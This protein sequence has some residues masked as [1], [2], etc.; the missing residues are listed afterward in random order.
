MKYNINVSPAWIAELGLLDDWGPEVNPLDI[1][2]DT[3]R[4]VAVRLKSGAVHLI[5]WQHVKNLPENDPPVAAILVDVLLEEEK[6]FGR[7]A[8]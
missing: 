8:S 2:A 6:I 7:K 4:A 5:S 3:A 1:P